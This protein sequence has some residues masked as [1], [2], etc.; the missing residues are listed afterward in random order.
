LFNF[1]LKKKSEDYFE[2]LGDVDELNA[3]LGL[4]KEYT[5]HSNS[6]L[7][8]CLEQIQCRLLDVGSAVATPLTTSSPTT[9]ERVQ[10]DKSAVQILEEWTDRLDA[11][12]PNLTNFILPGGGMSASHLHVAR[13]ICRRAERH[14]MPIVERGESDASILVYLNRL[15]DFLFV[16]AR[17]TS[18]LDNRSDIVYKK[19]SDTRDLIITEPDTKPRTTPKP[20]SASSNAPISPDSPNLSVS[21]GKTVDENIKLDIG[22]TSS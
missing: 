15:S 14:V 18:F 22:G 5:R 6:N 16:A 13:T 20:S 21:N 10:F 1:A 7:T 2:A 4:V 17:Y 9:I 3:Q 12:L 19:Q 11:Q 8:Y